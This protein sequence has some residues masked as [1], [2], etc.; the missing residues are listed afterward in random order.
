MYQKS[1]AQFSYLLYNQDIFTPVIEDISLCDLTKN[2]WTQ[3]RL[4]INQEICSA[5]SIEKIFKSKF[6]H[7]YA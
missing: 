3:S 6:K 7:H 1:V 4:T 5:I 2:S